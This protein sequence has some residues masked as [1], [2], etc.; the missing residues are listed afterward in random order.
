MKLRP[1]SATACRPG[2]SGRFAKPAAAGKANASG[3]VCQAEVGWG[4]S[5]S[6]PKFPARDRAGADAPAWQDLE[7]RVAGHSPGG[8]LPL[9]RWRKKR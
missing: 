7:V 2:T 8:L 5:P 1:A 9:W 3:K 6:N 4:V